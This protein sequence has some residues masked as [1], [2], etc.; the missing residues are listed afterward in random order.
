M[1]KITKEKFKLTLLKENLIQL[2]ILEEQEIVGEDIYEIHKGYKE[3]V[4]DKEYCVV[5]YGYDFASITREAM[6]VA[7]KQYASEKR[8]K[9]AVITDNFAHILLIRF[10]ILWNNPSTPVK[11]FNSK[12][13]AFKWLEE[14]C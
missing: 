7:A 4:G 10:Y 14:C 12:E 2:E 6:D 8:K 1:Q 5:V 9:V 11:L 13:K 3:L